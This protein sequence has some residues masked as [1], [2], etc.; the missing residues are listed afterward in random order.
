MPTV[1]C[2]AC[3]YVDELYRLW[4]IDSRDFWDSRQESKQLT[5]IVMIRLKG[6]IMTVIARPRLGAG[7]AGT[8]EVHAEFKVSQYS[9]KRRRCP[10][11]QNIDPRLRLKELK[12]WINILTIRVPTSPLI[13]VSNPV[14][15][16]TSGPPQL[17]RV[18]GS[19]VAFL[20]INLKFGQHAVEQF[21]PRFG[22]QKRFRM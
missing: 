10:C 19:P 11:V 1:C 21:V 8:A 3:A 15:F 9:H 5:C 16:D 13:V 22:G 17:L 18:P 14:S 20:S 4:L 2:P 6:T 12:P 7:L